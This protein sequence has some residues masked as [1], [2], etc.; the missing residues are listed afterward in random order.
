MSV[1]GSG[2]SYRSFAIA[3]QP[4]N[5]NWVAQGPYQLASYTVD[6]PET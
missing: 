2:R 3:M 1:A 5:G 4:L 6:G